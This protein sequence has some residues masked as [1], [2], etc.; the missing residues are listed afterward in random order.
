[1]KSLLIFL[2]AVGLTFSVNAQSVY[3]VQG[4]TGTSSYS[5]LT[6]AVAGASAG[7]YIYLPG[8]TVS[9]SDL[10]IDKQL[11]LIGAGHY[12]EATTATGP[13]HLSGAIN[14]VSG[15]EFSSI[16]GVYLTHDINFGTYDSND[17]ISNVL[18]SRCNLKNVHLGV[19]HNNYSDASN[20]HIKDCIIRDNVYVKNTLNNVIENCI[21]QGSIVGVMGSLNVNNCILF[22]NGQFLS[23]V[24]AANFKNCIFYSQNT[25]FIFANA[26]QPSLF[27]NCLFGFDPVSDNVNT[28]F[29]NCAKYTGTFDL[30]FENAPLN[31]FDYS[32]DYRLASG[33][34]AVGFGI[35]G[36]DAGIYGGSNP[37]KDNA[38][39][40][41]PHIVMKN[42]PGKTDGQG[43]LNITVQVQAQD[44]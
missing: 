11:H 30:L 28:I 15:A 18:I 23:S 40:I 19:Y 38:I 21:V 42:I 26:S 25:N 37:Y 10:I 44:Y 34:E 32:Y 1:M 31:I 3:T 39:P 36:T 29:H 6:A 8:G 9:V 33:S 4:E 2:L 41:N 35:E 27:Q 20:V 14:F 12:P 43:K 17:N 22:S 5:T 24:N 7:D 13:T 16:Q